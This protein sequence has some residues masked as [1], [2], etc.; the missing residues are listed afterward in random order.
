MVRSVRLLLHVANATIADEL[1]VRME[2]RDGAT[3]LPLANP[4]EPG[5]RQDPRTAWFIYDLRAT[6]PR[7]GVNRFTVRASRR[8]QRTADE[9]PL[10]IEDTELEIGY[11]GTRAGR[12]PAH[13]ATADVP[14][15]GLP[16]S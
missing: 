11:E 13:G 1:E 2:G 4:M 10:T 15:L 7:A 8:D 14:A 3:T 9:L 5:V 12:L 16:V 6:P